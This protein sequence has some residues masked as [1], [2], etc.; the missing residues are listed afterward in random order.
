MYLD[1]RDVN[2]IGFADIS[3]YPT[4]FNV[5]NPTFEIT[6]PGFPTINVPFTPKEANIYFADDLNI[7]TSD[8][9]ALPDG[10]Y[11]VKYSINPSLNLS[12]EKTILRIEQF[13]CKY[14]NVFLATD[15]ECQ[16][17]KEKLMEKKK[18]LQKAK[19]F[20]EGAVAGANNGDY[21]NSFKLYQKATSILDSISDC[22]CK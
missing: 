10:L 12:V 5:T 16:C 9:T 4:N 21:L 7:S 22:N 8:C 18:G 11:T 19:L 6:P 3:E 15:L 13:K 14:Y 20:I 17:S 2:S 1:T